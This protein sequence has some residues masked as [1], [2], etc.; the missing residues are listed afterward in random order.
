MTGRRSR[1]HGSVMLMTVFAIA[2]LSTIAIGLLELNTEEIQVMQNQVFTAQALAMAEAGLND[3]LAQIRLDAEWSDGFSDKSFNGG[4]YTV[5][6][7]DDTI[8]S[9][10]T[11][12]A[13]YRARV[14]A[15]ITVGSG[16]PHV[17]RIDALRI[18]E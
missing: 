13:G 8:T 2:L 11:T 15:D 12:S 18:N 17:I 9:T 16:P 6:V 3:A 5:T 4:T 7:S 1:D 14:E 10:A